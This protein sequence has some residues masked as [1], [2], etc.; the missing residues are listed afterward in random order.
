MQKEIAEPCGRGCHEFQELTRISFC[1]YF[2]AS[3]RDFRGHSKNKIP[4]NF[5]SKKTLS[6]RTSKA[7]E[8][9]CPVPA[10]Y[11]YFECL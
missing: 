1:V 11:L 9:I 7:S 5:L 2:L 3:S 10:E 6:L 4:T 8:A